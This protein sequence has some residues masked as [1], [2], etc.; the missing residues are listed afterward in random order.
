MIKIIREKLFFPH[1]PCRPATLLSIV[2][3]KLGPIF[4]PCPGGFFVVFNS[5]LKNRNSELR[6]KNSTYFLP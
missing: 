2:C 4:S 3:R 6:T 1:R 5:E